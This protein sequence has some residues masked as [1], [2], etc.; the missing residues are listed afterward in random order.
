MK[1]PEQQ[2]EKH[3]QFSIDNLD[4]ENSRVSG[5]FTHGEFHGK[6]S[7]P[8]KDTFYIEALGARLNQSNDTLIIYREMDIIE[9]YTSCTHTY[10]APPQTKDHKAK[11]RRVKRLS[12]NYNSCPILIAAD[13]MFYQYIGKRSVSTTL[14]KMAYYVSE[15]DTIFRSTRFFEE[16]NETIGVVI[17][18]L[19]VYKDQQ[20]EG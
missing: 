7:V 2:P 4:E 11:R 5:Y 17:A 3:D 15:A 13:N 12:P 6:I 8:D 20:S 18:S 1:L 16:R 10:K 14:A 19:V 9:N